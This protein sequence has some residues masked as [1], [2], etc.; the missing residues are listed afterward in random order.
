MKVFIKYPYMRL[1]LLSAIEFL[2]NS[3]SDWRI[4]E[5]DDDGKLVR[6]FDLDEAYHLLFDDMRG[7]EQDPRG[8]IGITL[9]NEAEADAIGKLHKAM[10]IVLDV[11]YPDDLDEDYVKTARWLAVVDG[12]EKALAIMGPPVHLQDMPPGSYP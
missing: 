11:D 7:M 8:H 10:M 3:R 4:E 5:Y 2:A 9:F 6:F 12:A 1:N